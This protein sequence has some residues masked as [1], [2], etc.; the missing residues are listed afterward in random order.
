MYTSS[1]EYDYN[2]TTIQMGFRRK[3]NDLYESVSQEFTLLIYVL[4]CRN[5]HLYRE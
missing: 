4:S 1:T 2:I 5:C 3:S